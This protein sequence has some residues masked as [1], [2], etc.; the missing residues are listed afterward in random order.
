MKILH[1]GQNIPDA[2]VEKSMITDLDAGNKVALV[3][4]NINSFTFDKLSDVPC[5]TMKVGFKEQIGRADNS[6][7]SQLASFIE[8][9][10]PDVIH[11]HDIYNAGFARLFDIPF[12]YND[13]EAW[14]FKIKETAPQ[15]SLI[16]KKYWR[17]YYGLRVRRKWILK[18][19]PEILKG[20]VTISVSDTLRKFHED[21]GATAYCIHNFPLKEEAKALQI[22]EKIENSI[23]YVGRDMRASSNPYRDTSGFLQAV[24]DQNLQLGVI[25]DD[26]LKSSGNIKSYGFVSHNQINEL[27]LPYEFG[28]LAYQP[29]PFHKFTD[30][31]K[32]YH[33]LFSGLYIIAPDSFSL[34]HI[35]F[36]TYFSDMSELRKVIEGT[37]KV[38]SKEIQKYAFSNFIWEGESK[39]QTE[40]TKLT[41]ERGV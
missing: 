35:P 22:D 28:A 18:N 29:S 27:L 8:D 9:F 31:V 24:K 10:D 32:M 14:S 3:G 1:L 12:L 7:K 4:T 20:R 37:N 39:K 26:S 13:H 15:G 40:A 5:F 23:A 36:V 6:V 17:R 33:Y 2:R 30:H 41:L 16:S 34:S 25:G 11:A 19:E 21:S 38:D